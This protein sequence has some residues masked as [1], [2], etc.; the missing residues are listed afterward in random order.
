MLEITCLKNTMMD[1]GGGKVK[2]GTSDTKVS[3]GFQWCEH[4]YKNWLYSIYSKQRQMILLIFRRSKSKT[5]IT[6]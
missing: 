5:L 1:F 4:I 6:L 2:H 3:N